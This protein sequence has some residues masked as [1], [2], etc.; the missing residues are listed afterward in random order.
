MMNA[1]FSLKGISLRGDIR[2]SQNLLRRPSGIRYFKRLT[3]VVI[4]LIVLFAGGAQDLDKSDRTRGKVMLRVIKKELQ[5]RY[6]DPTFHGLDLDGRFLK[7]ADD[8]D[9]AASLGQ[10]F[11]IIAQAV[12]DLND[13]HTRFVP[14][15]RAASFEY[16]WRMRVI[17]ETPY[18]LAVKPGSDAEVK[19][20]KTGDA[21][22]S[23][24]RIP[25]NR[26]NASTFKY[27]YYLVRPEP[28]LSLAVRDPEGR[29]RELEVE[30]K[31]EAGRRV[32]DITQG[33]DIWDILRRAENASDEHRFAESGDKDIFIWNIPS[34]MG[35][36]GVFKRNAGRLSNY[37][38]VVLDLRGN[39]GGYVDRLT[40]LLGCFFDHDV[41]VGQP[42]GRGK[43]IKPVV[44]KTRGQKAF[45]GKLVVI[46][47]ADTTSAAELFARVIQIEKRG[48][49][50]GDRT[51]GAV[52][53]TRYYSKEMGGENVVFYAISIA[54]SELIMADGGNLEKVGVTP[55]VIALPSPADLA[56]GRDP[57]MARAVALVGGLMT[58][59]D[60]GKLFPYKWV[61]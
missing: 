2:M 55:D 30:T 29:R 18:V 56:A 60:A 25:L 13:S 12:L 10:I 40:L 58:P 31:I 32:L 33:E 24:D 52:M 53:Q 36:E 39:P 28:V 19:G 34:F 38:S 57:V 42:R 41:T 46:V 50:V 22:L 61:D 49:V 44:A 35:D 11:G 45:A 9:Q 4:P 54:E 6:Y 3:A 37:K 1:P 20:L 43:D 7:A 5:N 21:L 16:G 59:V 8:I 14:P 27:R 23:V 48:T 15:R 17:G 26:Q 51:P 47:D